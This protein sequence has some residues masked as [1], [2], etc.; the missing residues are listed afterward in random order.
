MSKFVK[1]ERVVPISKTADGR[2]PGLENSVSWNRVKD[3]E[4]PYLIV[5]RTPLP[6]DYQEYMC[7]GDFFHESDLTAYGSVEEQALLR[8][9]RGFDHKY[10]AL[11]I[12]PKALQVNLSELIRLINNDDRIPICLIK[13]NDQDVFGMAE[14]LNIPMTTEIATD[15]L[16]RMS[17]HL[18]A[19]NGTTYD[20][21]EYWIREVHK[22]HM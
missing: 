2:V 14:K 17:R 15:I 11:G 1:G 7:S 5:E 21:L 20:T 8:L 16:S 22:E 18:D 19:E 10:L 3:S 13:W 4:N 6:D 9:Y 12:D